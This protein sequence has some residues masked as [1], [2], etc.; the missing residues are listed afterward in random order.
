MY[1]GATALTR[2]PSG[3]HSH[4][5]YFVRMFIAPLVIAYTAPL[6][7]ETKDATELLNTTAASPARLS[8][9]WNFWHSAN[10]ASR[11]VVMSARYSS[12][13][14]CV[15]GLRMLKPTLLTRMCTEPEKRDAHSATNASRDD[16]SATSHAEPVTARPSAR[17]R[18]TAASTSARV[19][20][21][22]CTRA[23]WQAS[24][25]TIARLRVSVRDGGGAGSE[26]VP[27]RVSSVRETW[28]TSVARRR[29]A[30]RS[31]GPGR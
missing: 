22:V 30:T 26:R 2:M 9:G 14:N 5:R 18:A 19:R 29:D 8:S 6:C 27:E 24:D 28:P 13:V 12:S 17:H 16:A 4:A 7:M 25:S 1:Q 11:F 10:D 21:H 15:V 3:A 31:R 20:A 23:P